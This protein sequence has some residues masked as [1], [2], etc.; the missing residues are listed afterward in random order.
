MYKIFYK[1]QNVDLDVKDQVIDFIKKLSDEDKV[2]NQMVVIDSEELGSMEIALGM[3]EE[4]IVFFIPVSEEEDI[5]VTCNQY[6]DRA[7]SEDVIVGHPLDEDIVCAESNLISLQDAF[8]I[9]EMFLN[10]EDI[11]TK[12]DWY[13]Y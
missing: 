5:K 8:D 10:K 13:S 7:K 3:G 11:F 6:V 9:L 4:S 12:V 2:K 1:D